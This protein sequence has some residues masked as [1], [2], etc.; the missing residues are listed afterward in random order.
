MIV[1]ELYEG[2]G[3]GNQLWVYVACR[4]IARRLGVAFGIQ[5]PEN[6]K[7]KNF[8]SLDFGHEVLGRRHKGP[9]G[10][11]PHGVENYFAEHRVL[12]PNGR[13]DISPFDPASLAI[14][15]S[16]KIDGL[17]QAEKY[18]F[19]EREAILRWF[20]SSR[21]LETEPR[22]CV[23]SF[24]GG[25]YRFIPE[26]LLPPTYYRRAMEVIRSESPNVDFVVVTDDYSFARAYF[27]DLR[28]VSRRR[29]PPLP[30]LI[31]KP[32]S[33]AI[34][35]DFTWLQ[36]VDYLILSNSSFSWWG[37][38]SSAQAPFVVAPKYWANFNANDGYWSM[39]DALT[40]DWLWLDPNGRIFT[41]DECL[42]E[43]K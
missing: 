7:G 32:R 12:H 2:Q 19:S 16:T 38:W 31:V 5:S 17:F 24:R 43:L 6:F 9:S 8:L 33:S 18:I 28:I 41:Y 37:A 14:G 39:G 40:K 35:L 10:E 1:T 22:T 13:T 3:L 42:G 29:V 25:E 4:V 30:G 21:H 11:L 23:I 36:S 20:R 15:D 27:P 34:G 26:V